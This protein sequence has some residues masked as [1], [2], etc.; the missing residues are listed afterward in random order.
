MSVSDVLGYWQTGMDFVEPLTA[1]LG[2]FT[3]GHA[4]V[5]AAVLVAVWR[6][7]TWSSLLDKIKH[8]KDFVSIK[9]IGIALA[10]LYVQL[11]DTPSLA[12]SAIISGGMCAARPFAFDSSLQSDQVSWQGLTGSNVVAIL[13]P[14]CIGKTTLLQQLGNK[15]GHPTVYLP[16]VDPAASLVDVLIT[17][18]RKRI[19]L[20][21]FLV[22][23]SGIKDRLMSKEAYLEQVF[24]AVHSDPAAK[25]K[26][27]LIA[28]DLDRPDGSVSAAM[29][30]FQTQARKLSQLLHV[31][32]VF[33]TSDALP[34]LGLKAENRDALFVLPEL[35]RPTSVAF[36]RHVI[37]R[38]LARTEDADPHAFEHEE[39]LQYV[40]YSDEQRKALAA[41][42]AEK[43]GNTTINAALDAMPLRNFV[44]IHNFVAEYVHNAALR[45]EEL[46]YFGD[47][48]ILDKIETHCSVTT[49]PFLKKMAETGGKL[50]GKQIDA[51]CKNKG[52]AHAL[53][54]HNVLRP[55]TTGRFQPSKH[56]EEFAWHSDAVEKAAMHVL[57]KAALGQ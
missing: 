49:Q 3:L 8:A 31:T 41:A 35:S 38:R 18:V 15:T 54:V 7:P 46:R 32:V 57:D 40:E 30:R 24:A 14:K 28:I 21:P 23:L 42:L 48:T 22:Y 25:G 1:A 53:L 2:I 4:A 26:K 55:A 45:L 13:G 16:D 34:V 36:A 6:R 37:E 9:T 19:A 47:V 5:L 27:A 29:N 20:H 52:A 50:R 44:V 17:A 39:P 56:Q 43:D 12:A 51:Q 10:G 11:Y 33:T